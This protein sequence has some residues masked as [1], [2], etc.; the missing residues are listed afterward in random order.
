MSDAIHDLGD[1]LSIGSSW[2]LQRKSNKKPDKKFT[3]GYKRLSLLAALINSL[4]LIIGSVF[5]IKEAVERFITPESSDPNGMLIFAILGV[6]INGYAA[7][8]IANGK[9]MNEKVLTWH[10]VEDVLGWVAVLIVSIILQ[11]KDYQFLDPALS[12]A[13][14]LFILFNVIKRLKETLYLFLQG[15]PREINPDEI[16]K[17]LLS[18]EHVKKIHHLHIWSLDGES[19]VFSVHVISQNIASLTE[20]K[21][22]KKDLKSSLHAFSFKHCTIEIELSDKDCSME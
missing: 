15:Q 22:L 4:V 5:I 18:H 12:L 9:S 1:S 11:F 14:T 17:L 6:L 8:K 10:L 13:I 19:H 21:E 2:Y 3:F 20:L 16:E 7:F